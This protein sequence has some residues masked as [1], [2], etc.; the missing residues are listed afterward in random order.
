MLYYKLTICA[1]S[2]LYELLLKKKAANFIAKKPVERATIG[3]AEIVC[4]LSM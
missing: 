2:K 1:R 4:V 3:H